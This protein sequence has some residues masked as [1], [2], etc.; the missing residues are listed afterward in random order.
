MEKITSLTE[1]HEEIDPPT[2]DW[3]VGAIP[4]NPDR[5]TT[6]HYVPVFCRNQRVDPPSR[7]WKKLVADWYDPFPKPRVRAAAD[8]DSAY[9][10]FLQFDDNDK[11]FGPAIHFGSTPSQID[12]VTLGA[13]WNQDPTSAQFGAAEGVQVLGTGEIIFWYVGCH[14]RRNLLYTGRSADRRRFARGSTEARSRCES[15]RHQPV[16]CP[17][18]I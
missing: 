6:R 10:I 5:P 12:N 3:W 13:R 9:S 8:Q 15:D 1:N 7:K 4:L 2:Y 11:T 16:R 17:H 14:G 18:L